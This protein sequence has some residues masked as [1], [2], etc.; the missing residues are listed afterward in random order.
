MFTGACAVAAAGVMF[1][2]VAAAA[3]T[4]QP[5]IAQAVALVGSVFNQAALE[6]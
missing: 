3:S 1:S 2:K 5:R 6:T 4:A